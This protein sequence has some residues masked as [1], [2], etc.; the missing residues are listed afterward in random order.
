MI[1]MYGKALFGLI[2]NAKFTRSNGKKILIINHGALGDFVH[3]IPLIQYLKDNGYSV[4]VSTKENNKIPGL[5]INYNV[6]GYTSYDIIFNINAPKSMWVGLFFANTFDLLGEKIGLKYIKKNW[7]EIHW[8]E[9]YLKT[10]QKILNLPDPKPLNR[11][12]TTK[13]AILIHPGGSFIG[14]SWGIDNFV[15]LANELCTKNKI[16]VILGPNEYDLAPHFIQNGSIEV[17]L[18]RNMEDLVNTMKY[19][20]MFIGNDSGV[21]HTASLFDIPVF[22]IY[23]VGCAT[24]HYPYTSKGFYYFDPEQFNSFYKHHKIT[25]SN[26]TKKMCFDQVISILD[27]KSI[28]INANFNFTRFSKGL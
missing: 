8:A 2:L 18:S 9:F 14:K 27:G 1:F 17:I 11:L 4:D 10:V 12:S 20:K 7:I 13:E 6:Q 25:Q 24:T 21:M 23:T 26:L 15:W 3:S 22:G 16:W 28:L 5:N 19:A